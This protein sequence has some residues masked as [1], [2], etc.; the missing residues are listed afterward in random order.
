M[1]RSGGGRFPGRFSH[2]GSPMDNWP[3]IIAMFIL[4]L[5]GAAIGATVA[6]A[7]RFWC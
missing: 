1:G 5:I 4:L 2:K 7:I 3:D 6:F